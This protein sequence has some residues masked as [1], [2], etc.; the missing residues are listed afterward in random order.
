M[1]NYEVPEIVELGS[2]GEQT[3]MSPLWGLE[4]TYWQFEDWN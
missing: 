4:E 1:A 2:F 3:G